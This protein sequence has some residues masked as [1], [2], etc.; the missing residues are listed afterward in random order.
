MRILLALLLLPTM[1][2]A[3]P[4][5]DPARALSVATADWNGDGLADRAVLVESEADETAAE[6]FIALGSSSGLGFQHVAH[7]DAIVWRGAMWGQQPYLEMRDEALFIT[8]LNDSIGRNRWK[9]ELSVLYRN[10]EFVVSGFSYSTR[11]TLELQPATECELD[12]LT[13]KGTFMRA[14]LTSQEVVSFQDPVPVS[15]WNLEYFPKVCR[16]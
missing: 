12:L 14:G 2:A 1:V 15:D 8:S 9:L 11:D 13:G 5:I 7:A 3:G 6:L 10:E 4:M 16:Y